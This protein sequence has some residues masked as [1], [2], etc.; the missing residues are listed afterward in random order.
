MNESEKVVGACAID[1]ISNLRA[2]KNKKLQIRL[3][4]PVKMEQDRNRC[5]FNLAKTAYLKNENIYIIIYE[6]MKWK[7]LKDIL[8]NKH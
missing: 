7:V 5:V 6:L 4:A 2:E 1:K 8:Y 3:H